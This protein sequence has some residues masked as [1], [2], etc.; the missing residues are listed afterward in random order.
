[1]THTTEVAKTAAPLSL[2][3]QR[4]RRGISLEAVAQATKISMQFLQAIEAEEFQKLPGG[5]Y[6]TNYIRQYAAFTGLDELSILARYIDFMDSVD[7][8][9]L[10]PQFGMSRF[11]C[12]Q[13]RL[14]SY[15]GRD[16]PPLTAESQRKQQILNT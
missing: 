9:C 4:R 15:L 7:P 3:E 16:T 10:P 8:A 13:R 12:G 11:Q 1:M 5:I 2:A 6:N 14:L